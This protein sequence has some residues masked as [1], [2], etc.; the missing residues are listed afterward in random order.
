MTNYK[1]YPF[2]FK[3]PYFWDLFTISFN[4]SYKRWVK[5]FSK[6]ESDNIREVVITDLEVDLS[7]KYIMLGKNLSNLLKIKSFLTTVHNIRGIP[8]ITIKVVGKKYAVEFFYQV[9]MHVINN[10]ASTYQQLVKEI[11]YW[12]K[13]VKVNNPRKHQQIK[14]ARFIA[15]QMIKL[16]YKYFNN[17]LKMLLAKQKALPNRCLLNSALVEA[18]HYVDKYRI[19]DWPLSKRNLVLLKGITK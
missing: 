10:D 19:K 16:E 17:Y 2:A 5:E 13:R 15:S 4:R 11:K 14:D 9:F 6:H 8:I 1:M 3:Q 7:V 18:E 12:K